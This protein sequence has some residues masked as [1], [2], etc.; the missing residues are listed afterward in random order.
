MS[1]FRRYD[2]K[3]KKCEKR[4]ELPTKE[5]GLQCCKQTVQRVY[6]VSGIS[7]KGSGWYSTDYKR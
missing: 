4:F 2:F 3:C 1:G 5:S 7:F 6:S